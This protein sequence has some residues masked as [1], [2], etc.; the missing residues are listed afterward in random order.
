M[1][2][3][4][5]VLVPL[6]IVQD[7]DGYA[8]TRD[9]PAMVERDATYCRAEA[10]DGS[11]S[12]DTE[13]EVTRYRRSVRRV[14]VLTGRAGRSARRLTRRWHAVFLAHPPV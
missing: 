14:A 7:L 1:A 6:G 9:Q 4:L 3:V 11:E 13:P 5:A 10:E 2:A 12:A 8:S